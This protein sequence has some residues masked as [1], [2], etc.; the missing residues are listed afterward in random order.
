M[1]HKYCI[2]KRYKFSSAIEKENTLSIKIIAPIDIFKKMQGIHKLVRVSPFSKGKVHTSLC[3]IWVDIKKPK[4]DIFIHK[5][6]IRIDFYKS[7]GPGGQHKNKTMSAV[8]I[9]HIPTGIIVTNSDSRSQ[10]DNKDKA[11]EQLQDI[12]DN[13][14]NKEQ[15]SQEKSLWKERNKNNH[16]ICSYYLNHHK[17]MTENIQ[18]SRVNEVLNGNLE[19][20]W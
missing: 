10:Y 18:S 19:L 11:F 5:E 17:I 16:V 2:N 8:R 4:K 15:S 3:S 14:E 6:D 9:L 13:L 7:S 1:I 20:I 12:L